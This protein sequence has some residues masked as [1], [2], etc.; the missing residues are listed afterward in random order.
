LLFSCPNS[1]SNSNPQNTGGID[2]DFVFFFNYTF[3]EITNILFIQNPIKIRDVKTAV[4]SVTCPRNSGIGTLSMYVLTVGRKT[5]YW[6]GY[7]QRAQAH[8]PGSTSVR[9]HPDAFGCF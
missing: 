5:G 1:I 4:L 7:M 6:K 3:P 9:V 8:A 2:D